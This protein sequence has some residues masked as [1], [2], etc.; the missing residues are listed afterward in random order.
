MNIKKSNEILISPDVH[1]YFSFDM[2]M[3]K[4]IFSILH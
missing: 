1:T 2:I 4:L 3:K